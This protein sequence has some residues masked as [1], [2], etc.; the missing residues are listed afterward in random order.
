M[1][2]CVWG[3]G[4]GG[5][6]LFCLPCLDR[7]RPVQRLRIP[8]SPHSASKACCQVIVHGMYVWRVALNY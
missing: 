2:V 1:C 6:V 7:F 3:G 5:G 8:M 4:G